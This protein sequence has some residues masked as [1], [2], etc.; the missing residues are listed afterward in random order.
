MWDGNIGW[1][2]QLFADFLPSDVLKNIFSFELHDDP[3]TV[4][5]IFWNGEASGGFTIKFA[6]QLIHNDEGE[7][8][9]PSWR[10]VWRQPIPQRMRFFIWLLLKNRLMSNVNRFSF[11]KFI[12]SPRFLY[13]TINFELSLFFICCI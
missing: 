5:R 10:A 13:T 6:L 3:D 1:K 12:Y 4:D 8:G 2:S 11:S 7:Q 9:Q